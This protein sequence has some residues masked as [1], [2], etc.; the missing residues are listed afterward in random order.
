MP[1]Q[2]VATEQ[3]QEYPQPTAPVDDIWVSDPRAGKA[4][5]AFC[6]ASSVLVCIAAAL[7]C[8]WRP[9]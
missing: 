8:G 5:L 2:T 7:M 9:F 1:N 3:H 6:C 4:C